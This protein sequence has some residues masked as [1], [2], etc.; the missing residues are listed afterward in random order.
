MQ[1]YPFRMGSYSQYLYDGCLRQWTASCYAKLP[2]PWKCSLESLPPTW[3]K[4]RWACKL[5]QQIL[6]KL[7]LIEQSF[8]STRSMCK[9]LVWKTFDYWW[10]CPKSRTFPSSKRPGAHAKT[11]TMLRHQ[12]RVHEQIDSRVSKTSL[13]W[14]KSPSRSW[15]PHFKR[16]KGALVPNSQQFDRHDCW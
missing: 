13:N 15:R 4:F 9:E 12:K 10:V 11:T 14:F 7:K 8:A 3:R 1:I 16:S 6:N 5:P 2:V